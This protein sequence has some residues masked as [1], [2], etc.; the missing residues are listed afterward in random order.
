MNSLDKKVIIRELFKKTHPDVLSKKDISENIN[1]LITEQ[2]QL[3]SG[4]FDVFKNTGDFWIDKNTFHWKNITLIKLSEN[5]KEYIKEQKEIDEINFYNFLK[6]LFMFHEIDFN[7]DSFEW[8]WNNNHFNFHGDKYEKKSDNVYN[9]REEKK[10]MYEEKIDE[11]NSE[12]KEKYW[13]EVGFDDCIGLFFTD[14]YLRHIDFLDKIDKLFWLIVDKND[15]NFIKKIKSVEVFSYGET[16]FINTQWILIINK[17]DLDKNDLS[18]I[19]FT[20]KHPVLSF[21][22]QWLRI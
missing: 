8:Y 3:I 5:W 17:K 20:I 12:L 11:K 19:Y 4:I 1:G 10:K 15:F 7:K 18:V 14:V 2:S 6:D 21:I 13:F 22:Y 9:K 16:R